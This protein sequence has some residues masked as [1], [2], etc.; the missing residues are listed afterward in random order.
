[1]PDYTNDLLNQ[2]HMQKSVNV[3]ANT[4]KNNTIF[5]EHKKMTVNNI[6]QLNTPLKIYHGLKDYS[7]NN[8]EQRIYN[9]IAFLTA[10]L[11]QRNYRLYHKKKIQSELILLSDEICPV[12]LM[13]IKIPYFTYVVKNTKI[14][15][16]AEDLANYLV[17]SG[18][19]EDPKT[20]IPY[21]DDD[22]LNIDNI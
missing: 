16:N 10:R 7:K 20:R 22:I 8:K 17:G 11:I 12:S 21:T 4:L 1:M 6:K 19:F 5:I 2:I 9:R 18:K 15:Y 14:Y 3:L 13:P